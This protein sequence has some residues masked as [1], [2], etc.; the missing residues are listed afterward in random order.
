MGFLVSL[1]AG[2]AILSVAT[3][4]T[5]REGQAGSG[6][7]CSH[8]PAGVPPCVAIQQRFGEQTVSTVHG[9]SAAI[10]IAAFAGL[11]LV[12]AL[13]DFGY[14]VAA[15]RNGGVDLGVRRV[16]ERARAD[17]LLAYL[18]QQ[19][20]RTL[21]YLACLLGVVLGAAWGELGAD[22][23]APHLYTGEFVAFTA[24]GSAWIVA[25]AD[26]LRGMLGRRKPRAGQAAGPG[27]PEVRA[28]DSEQEVGKQGE[29]S[30]LIS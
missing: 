8:H 2:L 3:F 11:C 28:V 12:F 4:P 9:Y 7:S 24:F 18:I 16:W 27:D 15:H 25:S 29:Q 10:A 6:A 14:G 17:G 5:A 21:L 19:A 13:R 23:L 1:V 22:W 30:E 20:P 26:L